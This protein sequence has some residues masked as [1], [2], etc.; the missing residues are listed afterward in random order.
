M[1]FARADTNRGVIGLDSVAGLLEPLDG[2]VSAVVG[3]V[4]A[5]RLKRGPG[6]VRGRIGG[7]GVSK[8][9]GGGGS[10]ADKGSVCA[11]VL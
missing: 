4:P 1:V 6:E 10:M 5:S 8:G 9:S 2:L 11:M 7:V 3:R